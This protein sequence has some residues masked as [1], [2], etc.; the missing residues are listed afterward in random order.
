MKRCSA[1]PTIT[2]L[3][4]LLYGTSL[5]SDYSAHEREIFRLEVV[6]ELSL[7]YMVCLP[8]YSGELEEGMFLA[9]RPM[10]KPIIA[11]FYDIRIRSFSSS[12]CT[13][14]SDYDLVYL[15]SACFSGTFFFPRQGRAWSLIEPWRRVVNSRRKLGGIGNVLDGRSTVGSAH[16]T[17]R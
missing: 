6:F 8:C 10:P 1:K 9:G 2:R 7:A 11:R 15:R 4:F 13:C 14:T 16:V 3:G 5:R 12:H 17:L